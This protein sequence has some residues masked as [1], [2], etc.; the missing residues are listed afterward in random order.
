MGV[1]SW[2]DNAWWWYGAFGAV[3][4]GLYMFVLP[5]VAKGRTTRQPAE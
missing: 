1:R 5:Y 3:L 2:R 4:A